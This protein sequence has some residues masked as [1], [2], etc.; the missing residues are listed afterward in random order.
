LKRSLILRAS[1]ALGVLGFVAG[2]LTAATANA[3]VAAR[4][5][6]HHGGGST[7]TGGTAPVAGPN[8]V[9]SGDLTETSTDGGVAFALSGTGWYANEG[10]SLASPGGMA[11]CPGFAPFPAAFGFIQATFPVADPLTVTT[12]FSGDFNVVAAGAGCAPGTYQV[13][14]QE[15]TTP[16]RVATT[17]L[18]ITSPA[19]A[20]PAGITL[21]P[22]SEVETG[23]S[24]QV[25]ATI[26]VHGLPP[27]IFYSASS[28]SLNAA[29]SGLKNVGDL[30]SDTGNGGSLVGYATGE[31]DFA[32]NDLVLY[33]AA[34]CNS[35]TY[36]WSVTE[37]G[38]GHTEF[39]A[40]FTVVAP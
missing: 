9:V 20:P 2:P 39:D 28:P 40:S 36:P 3:A 31:T 21:S 13:T 6:H 25:A 10:I 5:H 7:G 30:R 26:I 12:D 15:T 14:A 19:T 17:L 8:V 37:L 35:G 38:A 27:N 34:G 29:C 24:G 23:T 22:A 33:F 4:H 18:T 32:G 1:V 16:N 11:G